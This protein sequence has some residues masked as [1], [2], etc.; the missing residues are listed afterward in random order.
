MFRELGNAAKQI[1]AERGFVLSPLATPELCFDLVVPNQLRPRV[2]VLLKDGRVTLGPGPWPHET[3]ALW[4]G[5]P[6][7]ETPVERRTA[8]GLHTCPTVP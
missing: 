7:N 2:E 4:N 3:L 6:I 8:P 5:E 1:R